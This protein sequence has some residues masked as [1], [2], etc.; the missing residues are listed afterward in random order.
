MIYP[1]WSFRKWTWPVLGFL[2]ALPIP[3]VGLP[4]WTSPLLPNT[5]KKFYWTSG[6]LILVLLIWVIAV[7]HANRKDPP[8]GIEKWDDMKDFS[9]HEL[10]INASWTMVE[11]G[12]LIIVVLSFFLKDARYSIFGC[13]CGA[14]LLWMIGSTKIRDRGPDEF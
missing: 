7:I 14:G 12:C 1:M 8:A 9:W 11:I 10:F 3:F 5:P 6:V 13:L 2:A 4:N